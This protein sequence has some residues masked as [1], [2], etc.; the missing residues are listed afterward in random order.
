LISVTVNG[1]DITISDPTVTVDPSSK[2]HKQAGQPIKLRSG[3]H[4]LHISYGDLEF[5]TEKFTLRR[6]DK[7][8]LSVKLLDG[9]VQVALDDQVIDRKSLPPPY[10]LAFDG[11]KSYVEIPGSVCD[12][13][14]LTVEATITFVGDGSG[15]IVRCRA[16]DGTDTS[17]YTN[18][19]AQPVFGVH[20]NRQTIRDARYSKS[21]SG[22]RVHLAGVWDGTKPRLY[23]NGAPQ[24]HFPHEYTREAEV[25]RTGLRIG[26]NVRPNNGKPYMF[27]EGIIDEVRI[28]NVARYDK[29]FE[30]PKPGERFEPD[31]HTLALYHFD[32]GQGEIAHDSSPN[33]HHGK[34]IGAKW[35][36]ADLH[37]ARNPN[38]P[39]LPKPSTPTVALHR[40]FQGAQPQRAAAFDAS[41]KYIATS[42]KGGDLHV[43]NLETGEPIKLPF[44]VEKSIAQPIAFSP[45]P[46]VLAIGRGRF[47]VIWDI[48]AGETLE[49]P[50][51]GAIR[52]LQFHHSGDSVAVAYDLGA[53]ASRIA[54][55][56]IK[57]RES[58]QVITTKQRDYSLAFSPDGMTIASGGNDGVLLWR[59]DTGKQLAELD[60]NQT[61]NVRISNDGKFLAA[62]FP[63]KNIVRIW[64]V[65][66]QGI[67]R[68]FEVGGPDALAF[69]PDVR[70]I[71]VAGR[72][73]ASFTVYD[74]DGGSLL[75]KTMEHRGVFGLAFS[76]SGKMLASAGTDDKTVKIWKIQLPSA[77]P[78]RQATRWAIELGGEVDVRDLASGKESTISKLPLPEPTFELIGVSAQSRVIPDA[79]LQPLAGLKN[80][81]F[82]H[83]G[84]NS[85]LDDANVNVVM[86]LAS[87]RQL[88]LSVPQLTDNAF[89]NLGKLQELEMINLAAT[90]ITGATLATFEQLPRLEYVA[91]DYC[92][93]ITDADFKHLKGCKRLVSVT[94][95]GTNIGDAGLSYLESI[96][97]LKTVRCPGTKVT[98]T[99][100]AKLKAA[101]RCKIESDFTDEEIAVAM[102]NLTSD[103]KKEE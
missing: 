33:K 34:I 16:K 87:L 24:Q 48:N 52:A 35:V 95:N 78:D 101:L 98:V 69:S 53:E 41:E 23:I 99:G 84:K 18:A 26:A 8:V 58:K 19:G 76:P 15:S 30:P 29:D 38:L 103:E 20:D 60:P 72:N 51:G 61:T 92:K 86:T 91:L 70:C 27:F 68:E 10:A 54:L 90:Q 40:T 47:L 94:L 21:Y 50:F 14:Y 17:L 22:R 39:S 13:G 100:V 81:E 45:A 2:T 12:G 32:E 66:S 62:S 96:G 65:G 75:D 5:D 79:D 44:D 9:Q 97:S 43:W 77:E 56:M 55:C 83:L 49:V 1:E 6:G 11:E 102:E 28:S 31:E 37:Q 42:G 82:L 73:A 7:V 85:G 64:D 25:I 63:Y 74:I 57:D 59:I 46:G 89:S 4:T 3:E 93:S 80:I 71:A 88:I 36:K 67:K